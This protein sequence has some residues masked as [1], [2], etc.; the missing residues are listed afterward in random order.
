MVVWPAMSFSIEIRYM[1]LY[2][3]GMKMYDWISV[4]TVWYLSWDT[5]TRNGFDREA[6]C[7]DSTLLDIVAEKRNVRRSFGRIFRILS[8]IGPKSRSSNL[9]AS[10]MTRY[11]SDR[12]EKPLVFSR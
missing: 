4:E 6:R 5:D 1:S 12:N 3:W 11:L 8:R 9:S 2:L 10:S 7:S